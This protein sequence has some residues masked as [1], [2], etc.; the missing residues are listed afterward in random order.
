MS[1]GSFLKDKIVHIFAIFLTTVFIVIVL[2]GLKSNAYIIVLTLIVILIGSIITFCYEFLQR[3]SYYKFVYKSLNNLDK[4]YLLSEIINSPSFT[5]GKILF[6]VLQETNKSMNDNIAKYKQAS[7]E[8]REYIETWVHEIKTPIASSKLIVENNSNDITENIDE[9]I[10]KID[11]FVEQ[12]L[13]YSRSNNVEKDYIIKE[14]NLKNM[15]KNYIKSNAKLFINAKTEIKLSDDKLNYKVYT[16]TKW[17]DFIIS[18]IITNSLKYGSTTIKFY[19]KEMENCIYFSIEDNGIGIDI[20]DIDRVFEKGFTGKN[21][22]T[23]SRS[24]GMGLF[25]CKKLCIKMGLN[26]FAESKSKIGTVI[27][28]VFPKSSMH[29]I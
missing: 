24:T 23:T 13:F 25:L 20:E 7:E 8:Y 10:E 9:E 3:Y 26:I 15:L 11:K 5:E 1:I 4:K 21:G 29:E 22:R 2:L 19:A 12:A 16:D 17:F 28:I 6:D 27:T 18:Q 14:A